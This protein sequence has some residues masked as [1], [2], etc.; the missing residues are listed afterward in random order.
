MINKTLL[1]ILMF[2]SL[3][4]FVAAADIPSAIPPA[5]EP[6]PLLRI[7]SCM[8]SDGGLN[9]YE[10]GV[11]TFEVVEWTDD[12]PSFRLPENTGNTQ[13]RC[14]R[15]IDVKES[16]SSFESILVESLCG[17]NEVNLVEEDAILYTEYDC[18]SEGKVCYSGACVDKDELEKNP[19]YLKE[20][21]ECNQQTAQIFSFWKKIYYWF[22]NPSGK[23]S[24]SETKGVV[25]DMEG[26]SLQGV[27]VSL[28]SNCAVG[29]FSTESHV[30]ETVTDSNGEFSFKEFQL[31]SAVPEKHCKKSISVAK[32]NYCPYREDRKIEYFHCLRELQANSFSELDSAYYSDSIISGAKG[33]VALGNRDSMTVGA[34]D[35]DVSFVLK[36]IDPNKDY[37]EEISN[38]EKS[39]DDQ[40]L[41]LSS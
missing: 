7:V 29:H 39:M 40:V 34:K 37:S 14:K 11:F 25:R 24:F 35:I 38:L 22:L 23:V 10:P 3:P 12:S 6:E 32:L 4:S 18:S 17:G 1:I 20:R 2:C 5:P 31:K 19:S 26:N 28:F 8:D 15:S 13:D 27:E 21:E 33:S 41:E 16:C 36:E 30:G 9:Y